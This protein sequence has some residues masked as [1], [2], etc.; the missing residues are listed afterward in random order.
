MNI[1]WLHAFTGRIR[2]NYAPTSTHVCYLHKLSCSNVILSQMR[3]NTSKCLTFPSGFVNMSKLFFSDGMYYTWSSFLRTNYRT[4]LSLTLMCFEPLNGSFSTVAKILPDS[5]SDL[6]MVG[7]S[8]WRPLSSNT[9]RIQTIYWTEM[10]KEKY[11]A[12]KV[13]SETDYFFLAL[14][15]TITSTSFTKKPLIDLRYVISTA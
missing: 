8:K 4:K 5:L 15:L 3:S 11:S 1:L 14:Q 10:D 12:S 2:I 9:F 6:I 13:D 7:P